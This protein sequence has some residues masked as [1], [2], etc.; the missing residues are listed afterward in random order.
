M[1][2]GVDKP[3]VVCYNNY[4]ATVKERDFDMAKVKNTD[5][6][7][8]GSCV[9]SVCGVRKDNLEFGFYLNRKTKDGY[10]VRTNTCCA[11][12]S[13][14]KGKEIRDAKKVAKAMGRPRPKIG[15]LCDCCK[16]P[17]YKKRDDIPD[18]I[19]GRWSWQCDHDHETGKFR[20]WICKT[21]NTGVC[22]DTISAAENALNYLRNTKDD[23]NRT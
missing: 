15:D 4:T 8:M 19:E 3:F 16:R 7:P 10:R 6:I 21:C 22:S 12:C 5:N 11:S 13:K 1:I 23:N 9:C 18:G 14:E 2:L 17:V 20:G